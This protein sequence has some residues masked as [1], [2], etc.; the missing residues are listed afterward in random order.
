M[1]D[2]CLFCKII[3]GEVPS[4]KV[5]EDD[6][7]YAFDDIEPEAPVHTLVVPKKHY[8]DLQ[9]NVPADVLGRLLSTVP[10]VAK[11]KGVDESGYR[12]IM[13]VGPDSA[14]TVQHLHAHI[15]GGVRMGRYTFE[16]SWRVP[17]KEDKE[18]K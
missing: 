11:L 2:D 10:V 13:N 6:F 8:D 9:D 14:Q 5:Y 17:K 16:N 12:V 1:S 7:C 3:A 15:V 18:D 4:K